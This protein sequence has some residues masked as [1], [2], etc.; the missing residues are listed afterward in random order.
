MKEEKSLIQRLTEK[1][2]SPNDVYVGIIGRQYEKQATTKNQI[3]EDCISSSMGN[4]IYRWGY[5][6]V[7]QPIGFFVKTIGGYKRISSGE[8]YKVATY[9]TM[10][11]VVIIKGKILPLVNV[12]ADLYWRLKEKYKYMTPEKARFFEEKLNENQVFID[13]ALNSLY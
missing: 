9:K 7:D 1:R 3:I 6:P 2:Y 5:K 10:D 4:I 8:K 12:Y 11:K 13:K